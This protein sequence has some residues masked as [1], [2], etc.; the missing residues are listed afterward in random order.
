MHRHIPLLKPL[1]VHTLF[2]LPS[3]SLHFSRVKLRS[4]ASTLAVAVTTLLMRFYVLSF[5]YYYYG[6]I[7]LS[8]L[9]LSLYY[10]DFK[11]Y[12]N[13]MTRHAR[14]RGSRSRQLHKNS[15][16][17]SFILLFDLSPDFNCQL[18]ASVTRVR[19]GKV[20]KQTRVR[21]KMFLFPWNIFII[22]ELVLHPSQNSRSRYTG[23]VSCYI[24]Q[25]HYHLFITRRGR[26]SHAG[27]CIHV[28]ERVHLVYTSWI[29]SSRRILMSLKATNSRIN[30]K[31]T[32]I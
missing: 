9:F 13:S 20:S 14:V 25:D 31:S 24:Q 18:M 27:S 17:A 16:F 22:R 5:K 7:F 4:P 30:A 32:R 10:N 28:Q 11:C 3:L 2:R 15:S 21:A 19:K 8:F 12:R 23:T 1:F 29:Q 26:M 6:S